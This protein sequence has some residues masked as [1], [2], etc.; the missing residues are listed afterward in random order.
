MGLLDFWIGDR[1][2]KRGRQSEPTSSNNKAEIGA[3]GTINMGGYLIAS[4]YNVNLR[5]PKRAFAVW[6][7]MRRSD[8]AVRETLWHVFANILNA[9]WAVHPPE[10]GDELDDELAAFGNAAFFEWPAQPFT[11]FLRHALDYLTYGSMVFEEVLQVIDAELRIDR[12]APK[13]GAPTEA[14]TAADI[15]GL[16]AVE[17]L[18]PEQPE[19]EEVTLPSRQFLTWR[20]F[21]PRMPDT[22]TEWRLDDV[23]ELRSIVQQVFKA[24]AEGG[25]WVEVEIPAEQLLVFTHE[26]FGDEFTGISILRSAYKPW[27]YKEMIEKISAIAFE[28]HGVGVP[29]AY[30]PREREG[31]EELAE[32]IEGFLQNL[33]AGEQSYILFPGPRTTGNIPGFDFEIVGMTGAVPPFKEMLEYYRGEIAGALLAR[34]KELGHA[35]TG[36]RATANVQSEVWYNVLHAI[37]RYIEDVANA[38]LRRLIDLNYPDV[39]R[40]PKLKASGIESRNIL[41]LAQSLALLQGSELL[42]PDTGTRAWV[43]GAIDA[44]AED[45][46]EAEMMRQQQQLQMKLE[47]LGG[48]GLNDPADTARPR[49]PDSSS[50]RRTQDGTKG[51]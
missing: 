18:Q 30:I 2:R 46:E 4:E 37:A 19:H 15:P 20:R 31:D 23:G 24:T 29:V 32:E 41:E 47:S 1:Q 25:T 48:L 45:E 51:T 28:R 40:Y 3:S 10:N 27:V 5:D 21:A 38:S 34:F 9:D 7:K 17:E 44:P 16:D 22:I 36:A 26:R 50:Q 33:R 42:Y 12:I 49:N 14:A 13:P 11:E 8:P 35:Q 39:E 6:E 43:R